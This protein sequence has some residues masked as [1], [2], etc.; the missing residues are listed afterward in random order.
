ML[1]I[2]IINGP[3]LNILGKRQ[4]HIYG[5]QN[6]E[7]YFDTLKKKYKKVELSYFQSNKEGEI[8]DALQN[9]DGDYHGIVLNA[10]AYTHTSIAI[11]DA[12]SAIST[13]VIEIH[14][15]NVYARENFRH[16]SY[17]APYCKGVIT[18]FGLIG[19]QMAIDCFIQEN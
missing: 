4:P 2:K 5:Y 9:A 1:K 18:G 16:T 15:T 11:A 8:I 7:D 6:F 13:P 10:A 17:L 3:N 14:I 12:I 19:Y